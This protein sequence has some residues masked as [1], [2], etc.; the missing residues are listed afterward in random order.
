MSRPKKG[1]YERY[2]DRTLFRV[3][4]NYLLP[5]QKVGGIPREDFEKKLAECGVESRW[6]GVYDHGGPRFSSNFIP[7]SKRV[8]G[9]LTSELKRWVDI[10]HQAGMNAVTWCAV[11]HCESGWAEHPEWRLVY[12][13]ENQ[14]LKHSCCI[15]TSYGEA[16]IG[17][18][19]EFFEKFNLDGI[20]FDGAN[21]TGFPLRSGCIC[22]DCRQKFETETGCVSPKTVNFGNKVFRV[23]VQW[24]FDMYSAYLKKLV[25]AIH[26][27]YPDK[28][29]GINHYHRYDPNAW[30]TA[31]PLDPFEC[32]IV[33]GSEST[34]R[35]DLASFSAKL[36]SAYGR[37]H[38]DVWTATFRWKGGK[39]WQFH[40]PLALM[41]H[42][43]ACL[44]FGGYPVFGF[45]TDIPA[46]AMSAYAESFFKPAADFLRRRSP[47]VE[48]ESANP[49]ALHISQQTETFFFGRNPDSPGFGWY[50]ES[51]LGWDQMLNETGLG[52]D[53]IFDKHLNA[54]RLKRYNVVILPLSLGLSEEQ[55]K[56]LKEYVRN[57]GVL[58][59]GPWAGRLDVAGE[60]VVGGGVLEE[61]RSVD[62]GIVPAADKFARNTVYLKNQAVNISGLHGFGVFTMAAEQTAKNGAETVMFQ[63][64]TAVAKGDLSFLYDR[65]LPKKAAERVLSAVTRRRFGKGHVID[66]AADWGASFYYAPSSPMRKTLISTL[67]DLTVFPIAVKA[68]ACV[69]TAFRKEKGGGLLIHLH[70]CPVTIHQSGN[71]HIPTPE[72]CYANIIPRDIIPICDVN[73]EVRGLK[74]KKANRLVEKPESLSVEKNGGVLIIRL[75][76]LDLHE[77]VNLSF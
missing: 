38:F 6:I 5:D 63:E 27:R 31:C 12:M 35:T 13:D 18:T 7:I 2:Y 52:S 64:E 73:I 71:S 44:T 59:L 23:W 4:E 15:N 58:V 42:A 60:P 24:R 51:V 43:A 46:G 76:R 39:N 67:E 61:L 50:W 20:W 3:S 22:P 77:I 21:F 54:E 14:D 45:E 26:A 72:V 25:D 29:I 47:Y 36:A 11:S 34:G 30:L 16:L 48:I 66:L 69:S 37:K 8:P 75:G 70:N 19:L 53:F 65:D 68:P 17:M 40:E 33:T 10:V 55:G 49:V 62:E 56:I 1:N 57:G 32:D 41:H 28:V 74:I 9:D